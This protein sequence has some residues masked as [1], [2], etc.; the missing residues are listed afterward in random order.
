[1]FVPAVWKLNISPRVQIF[2]WLVSH[3]KILTRDNLAKHQHVNDPS[4]LFYEEIETMEYLRF[5]CDLTRL[6]N[7]EKCI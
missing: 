1:V 7:M 5:R 3:N 4:C 2:M 6:I